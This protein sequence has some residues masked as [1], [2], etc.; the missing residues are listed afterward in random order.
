MVETTPQAVRAR[1]L[2]RQLEPFVAGPAG[3]HRGPEEFR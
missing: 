2:R 3:G 1:D